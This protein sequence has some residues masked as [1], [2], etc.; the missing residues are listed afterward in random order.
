[1]TRA[2]HADDA[3]QHMLAL[4]FILSVIAGSTD[5]IGF[6]ALGGLFTA[7]ITGNLVILATRVIAGDPAILSYIL[8]V[9][10]FMLALLLTRVISIYLEQRHI[11]TLR[12]LLCLQLLLLASFLIL[13]VIGGEHLD[14]KAPLAIAAGMS[15]GDGHGCANRAG[16][17]FVGE[18]TV[19]GRDDYE[20]YSVR[21]GAG[22]ADCEP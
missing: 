16:P 5:V 1:M 10:V 4:R 6:L 2:I 18:R 7:Q 22:G 3:A 13:G 12:P 21:A 17:N 9:P 15:G 14:A 11:M 19:D 8:S 20:C